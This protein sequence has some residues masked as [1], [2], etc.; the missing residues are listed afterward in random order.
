MV[1]KMFKIFHMQFVVCFFFS[2]TVIA[3]EQNKDC[4]LSSPDIP[5]Y[6]FKYQHFFLTDGLPKLKAEVKVIFYDPGN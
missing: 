2:D 1:A 4:W 5:E 3:C 6:H